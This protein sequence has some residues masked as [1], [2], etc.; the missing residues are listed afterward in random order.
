MTDRIFAIILAIV[1]ANLAFDLAVR[2]FALSQYPTNAAIWIHVI[3][4]GIALGGVL[5]LLRTLRKRR[6]YE[7]PEEEKKG[8]EEQYSNHRR[9]RIYSTTDIHTH[10]QNNPQ[11]K[12]SQAKQDQ[13][14][15]S[16]SELHW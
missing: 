13:E 16:P 4:N 8:E 10:H 15:S 1:L 14:V 5:W 11:Q 3:V 9:P 2:L 6:I 12:E 7:D